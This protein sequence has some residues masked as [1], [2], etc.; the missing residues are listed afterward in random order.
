MYFV[1][2]AEGRQSGL[3]RV[4]WTGAPSIARHEAGTVEPS[5]AGVPVPTFGSDSTTPM[6]GCAMRASGTG[7]ASAR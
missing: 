1:T 6:R 2:A 4:K 3:Y 5:D 7:D